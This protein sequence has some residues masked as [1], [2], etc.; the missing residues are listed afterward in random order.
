MWLTRLAIDR[1]R[2]GPEKRETEFAPYP[3]ALAH[4]LAAA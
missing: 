3:E 4:E 2:K 1:I